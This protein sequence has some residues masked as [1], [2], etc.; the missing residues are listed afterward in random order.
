MLIFSEVLTM[1][2]IFKTLLELV[3]MVFVLAGCSNPAGPEIPEIPEDNT[4]L[5]KVEFVWDERN[6]DFENY[7]LKY[8]LGL[9]CDE[10]E[11][12]FYGLPEGYDSESYSNLVKNDRERLKKLTE[13]AFEEVFGTKYCE[14]V[15]II[16]LTKWT[17]KAM[18]ISDKGKIS[19]IET[20]SYFSTEDISS[21][22]IYDIKSYGIE[23]PF[24]Q[25]VVGNE[26]IVIYVCFNNK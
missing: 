21:A 10:E 18:R 24:D 3:L 17:S 11:N 4:R 5:V 8:F 26:D 23:S 25:V 22:E 12:Y 16:N 2:H 7:A 15:T 14:E 6:E 13:D 9:Y 19:G 20:W 1:K